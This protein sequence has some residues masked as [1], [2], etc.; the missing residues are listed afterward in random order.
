MRNLMLLALA[1]LLAASSALAV[2][3]TANV[4]WTAPTTYSDGT[5]LPAT[6]IASY[7]ITWSPVSPYAKA[8]TVT[9]ASTAG[10]ATVTNLSCGSYNFTVTVTTSATAYSPNSSATSPVVVYNTGIA[11]VA[12]KPSSFTITLS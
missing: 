7:T 11:C 8:G 9:A 1:A 4:A 12:P 2:G 3:T 10:S 5:A 6:D